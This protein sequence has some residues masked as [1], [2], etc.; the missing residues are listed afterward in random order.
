MTLAWLDLTEVK[1]HAAKLVEDLHRIKTGGAARGDKLAVVGKRIDK[2]LEDA[3]QFELSQSLNIYKKAQLLSSVR[4]GLAGK[5]WEPADIEAI[6]H[7]MLT[8]R[9][10]KASKP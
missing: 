2:A 3:A 5:K 6:V 9:L 4:E 10:R 1:K 7:Q 8:F